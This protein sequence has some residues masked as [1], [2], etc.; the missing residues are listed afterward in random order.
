MQALGTVLL[1]AQEDSMREPRAIEGS[2]ELIPNQIRSAF[3]AIV[4]STHTLA[5]N[6]GTELMEKTG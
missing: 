1:I 2:C 6:M 5:A 3:C 4:G